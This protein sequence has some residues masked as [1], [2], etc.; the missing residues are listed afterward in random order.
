[1]N[2]SNN[3]FALYQEAVEEQPQMMQHDDGSKS[4]WLHGQLHRRDG[5]A[6]DRDVFKAWYLHNVLHREDGPAAESASGYKAWYLHGKSY[7]N[8]EAWAEALLKHRNKPHDDAAVAAF[9]KPI[10]KK[11]IAL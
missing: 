2:D 1:M 9:L 10:L 5:P 4:W 3:I 7:A 6:I 11:T 8:A